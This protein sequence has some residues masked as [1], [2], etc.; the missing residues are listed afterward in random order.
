[1]CTVYKEESSFGV[2]IGFKSWLPL[3]CWVTVLCWDLSKNC[4]G[5]WQASLWLCPA[6]LCN[7]QQYILWAILILPLTKTTLHSP[8]SL[9][10][11]LFQDP[12]TDT[13]SLLL[14]WQLLVKSNQN[15]ELKQANKGPQ[16]NKATV[17][18]RADLV[19]TWMF[20]AKRFLGEESVPVETGRLR[21][22]EII[23]GCWT[24]QSLLCI[25][26][27]LLSWK[28]ISGQ[29][30]WWCLKIQRGKKN[31]KEHDHKALKHSRGHVEE[32]SLFPPIW[33][34][35][36]WSM[37]ILSEYINNSP[38]GLV[39]YVNFKSFSGKKS[40]M[41][42]FKNVFSCIFPNQII[43]QGTFWVEFDGCQECPSV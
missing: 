27:Q 26:T 4:R 37:V 8:V 16:A 9:H 1:M 41:W 10:C 5:Y 39:V 30:S 33:I 18:V 40:A 2:Q 31:P 29:K 3:T 34:D 23:R 7:T 12:I 20:S 21:K 38:G 11:F 19:T 22:H 6:S 25:Q 42:Q 32:T 15:W 28:V 14:R 36:S 13:L 17:R 35:F 24:L 43:L